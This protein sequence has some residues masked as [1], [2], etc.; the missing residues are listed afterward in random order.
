MREGKE[1]IDIGTDP[2]RA[3]RSPWYQLEKQLIE[4]RGYPVTSVPH[5]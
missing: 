4:R 3:V 1:I 2:T 5:P